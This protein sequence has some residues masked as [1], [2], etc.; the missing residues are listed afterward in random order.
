MSFCHFLALC[1]Q[2]KRSAS[3]IFHL[4]MRRRMRDRFGANPLCIANHAALGKCGGTGIKCCVGAHAQKKTTQRLWPKC[5]G[6]MF[7]VCNKFVLVSLRN[8]RKLIFCSGADGVFF[9]NQRAC[10]SYLLIFVTFFA[11]WLYWLWKFILSS[12]T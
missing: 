10:L 11:T 6:D 1:E 2:H 7:G 5:V 3:V 4:G 8:D 12:S 9:S